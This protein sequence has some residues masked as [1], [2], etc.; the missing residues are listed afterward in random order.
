MLELQDGGLRLTMC[1]RCVSI[2]QRNYRFGSTFFYGIACLFGLLAPFVIAAE[3]RQFGAR[4]ALE[5]AGLLLLIIGGTGAT[6]WGIR[7]FGS[8]VR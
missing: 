5:A 3:L 1:R 6:G 4:T 2:T 8:R 7:H